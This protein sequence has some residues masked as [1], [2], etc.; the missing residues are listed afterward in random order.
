MLFDKDATS[1]IVSVA[2]PLKWGPQCRKNPTLLGYF[3]L[4][5]LRYKLGWKL[6]CILGSFAPYGVPLESTGGRLPDSIFR[7]VTSISEQ[8]FKLESAMPLTSVNDSQV[9][10]L[11]PI[12]RSYLVTPGRDVIVQLG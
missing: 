12:P 7:L 8:S 4:A 3:S 6:S 9:R 1:I 10:I 5:H 2:S 11:H